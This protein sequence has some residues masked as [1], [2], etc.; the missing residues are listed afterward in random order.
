MDFQADSFYEQI[1]KD[2]E[3]SSFI[4]NSCLYFLGEQYK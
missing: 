1:S 2:K 3:S 4:D